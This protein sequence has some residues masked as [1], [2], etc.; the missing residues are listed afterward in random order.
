VH[1]GPEGK[2]QRRLPRGSNI[3]ATRATGLIAVAAV[4]AAFTIPIEELCS[5]RRSA[6]IAFA[7]QNAMYL[8]HVAFGLSFTAVGRAFGRDRTTAAHACRV[9]EERRTD[10]AFDAR[11]ALLEH[12]LRR[13]R[14]VAA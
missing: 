4:A 14:E 8:T 11:M 1:T 3:A 5:K 6:P 13:K 7:R 12:A 9:V 10:P 2:G